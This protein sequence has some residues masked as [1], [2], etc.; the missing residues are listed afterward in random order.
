MG[1][2]RILIRS[3]VEPHIHIS[4]YSSLNS[5]RLVSHH[6]VNEFFKILAHSNSYEFMACWQ[7]YIRIEE[8]FSGSWIEFKLLFWVQV[9]I[10]NAEI[11]QK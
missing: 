8:M 7:R 1:G 10:N 11:S 3:C 9:P 5:Q 6:D 4:Q 2:I